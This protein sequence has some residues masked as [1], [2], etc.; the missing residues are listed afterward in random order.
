MIWVAEMRK[1][2]TAEFH[3]VKAPA[4]VF[5]MEK[6]LSKV[7]YLL[8]HLLN[9]QVSRVLGL[10][11]F[12]PEVLRLFQSHYKTIISRYG[13]YSFI[14]KKWNCLENLFTEGES[15]CVALARFLARTK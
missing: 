3:T 8:F 7:F 2:G 5:R 13:K 11:H 1:V 9:S 4:T 10:Y 15:F 6:G 14:H 12:F